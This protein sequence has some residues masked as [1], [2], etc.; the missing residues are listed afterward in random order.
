MTIHYNTMTPKCPYCDHDMNAEEMSYGKPTCEV[1]LLALAP[2]DVRVVIE[3][4]V[5]DEQF[6]LH[7]IYTPKYTS[8]Y[9]EYDLLEDI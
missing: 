5:C 7:C 9:S 6:W 3:C 8:T 2:D 4:P 1:D